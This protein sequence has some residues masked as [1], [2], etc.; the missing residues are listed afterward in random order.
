MISF[1][2]FLLFLSFPFPLDDWLAAVR[3]YMQTALN[4]NPLA[5]TSLLSSRLLNSSIIWT[6]T[7]DVSFLILPWLPALPSPDCWSPASPILW[8]NSL[9]SVS[10]SV[11]STYLSVSPIIYLSPPYWIYFPSE[12]WLI[13]SLYIP[14]RQQAEC[15]PC[16]LLLYQNLAGW[17]NYSKCILDKIK[18]WHIS[19]YRNVI[20]TFH[21]MVEITM[22]M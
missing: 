13:A 1:L 18:A 8:A 2:R 14:C 20:W 17:L 21:Y 3:I 11:F 6:L 16:S 5:Q 7:L 10:V 9:M 15:F 12:P 19:S 4:S 22:T